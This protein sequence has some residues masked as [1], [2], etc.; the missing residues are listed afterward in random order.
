MQKAK[1][2]H[3]VSVCSE[4]GCT[5]GSHGQTTSESH[6]PKEPKRYDG[7]KTASAALSVAKLQH[8]RAQ[9]HSRL[10]AETEFAHNFN[11]KVAENQTHRKG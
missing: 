2:K 8:R 9:E 4:A 3:M 1:C 5:A 10:S 7:E 11:L 6:T